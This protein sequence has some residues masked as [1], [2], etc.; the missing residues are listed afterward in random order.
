MNQHSY[1]PDPSERTLLG[2][3]YLAGSISEVLNVVYIFRF[4][5]LYMVMER[6]E[7]AVLPMFVESAAIF[8]LEIPTGAV[9]DRW[10]RK[11][12]VISGGILFAFSLALT[13][14]A[15]NH[16]G[17]E[18]L[19]SVCLIFA[20]G[21]LGQ[22]LVSGAQEAWVVD[23]LNSAGRS[24]LID[25]YFGRINSFVSIGG[26]GAGLLALTILY[27]T[28]VSRFVLDMLWYLAASGFLLSMFIAAFI[29][30]HRPTQSDAVK[31]VEQQHLWK[32]VLTGFHVI[33]R[34]RPLALLTIAI[35]IA[36]F[37]DSIA[38]EAFDI[39]LVTRGLD[40]RALAMLGIFADLIGVIA[41]L[42][43]VVLARKFGAS[44]VLSVFLI[45]P[46]VVVGTFFSEPALW[47]VLV[48]YALLVFFDGIWDPVA[49]ARL[50]SMIPSASR[51]TVGSTVNQLGGVARLGGIGLFGLLLG[52][53]SEAL[54]E[55]MPDLVD[56]F[57]G[58]VSTHLD[59]PIGLFGLPIPDLAI[60]VF[61]VVGLA[62]IPFL[63]GGRAYEIHEEGK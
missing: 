30:E 42:V 52:E 2:P 32:R 10:G 27:S 45:L 62:A 36:S 15:V 35:V 12:S 55:A 17:I 40:G 13:P 38:D 5:Y 18:Q 54:S 50:H 7:W 53:H 61:V 4:V 51:A 1:W 14:Y 24:D 46:A 56:A 43:G 34:L 33:L 3:F 21:G 29:S 16:Q 39:S 25:R 47:L 28:Q 41:P 59:I 26:V 63:L 31:P 11:R 58:G 23:N 44:W 6:P 20:L 8:F 9:A 48:M 60:V 22:T 57:S 19:W 37:S 49:D